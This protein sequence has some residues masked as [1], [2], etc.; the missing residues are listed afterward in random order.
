VLDA[1]VEGSPAHLYATHQ[2][3]NVRAIGTS[4]GAAMHTEGDVVVIMSTT[5]YD[6]DGVEQTESV[7]YRDFAVEGG[8]LAGFVVNET[9]VADRI[10]A[11]GEPVTVDD[12]SV[13]VVTAYQTARGD[14]T[15]N[16]D[17]TNGRQDVLNVSS[18]EWALMTP[19]GR[20]VA[21]SQNFCCPTDPVIQPGA[22]AGYVAA[23]EQVGLGGTLR[24]VAFADDF[25]TEVRFDVPVPA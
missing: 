25:V 5:G 2:I 10:R 24:F 4:L 18:Y 16:V 23:F 12:V 19:D 9:P 6:A 20:Q 1:S 11:G 21:L 3:A 15:I 7:T 22:T 8:K 14:L 17:T 13:R